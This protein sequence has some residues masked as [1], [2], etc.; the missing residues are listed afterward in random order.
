M[1]W[2]VVANGGRAKALSHQDSQSNGGVGSGGGSETI[3]F[4]G[5]LSKLRGFLVAGSL[6]FD[7]E[8]RLL[9]ESGGEGEGAS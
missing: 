7:S 5:I 4:L 9:R 6:E 8:K 3:C 1:G 2:F